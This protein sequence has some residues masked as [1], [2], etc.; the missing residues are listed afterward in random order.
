MKSLIARIRALGARETCQRPRQPDAKIAIRAKAIRARLAGAQ[1]CGTARQ[2]RDLAEK[3]QLEAGEK[4]A[5]AEQLVQSRRPWALVWCTTAWEP[6]NSWPGRRLVGWM[7]QPE[8]RLGTVQEVAQH[9]DKERLYALWLKG[10][11]SARRHGPVP[12]DGGD[13]TTDFIQ[14]TRLSDRHSLELFRHY[15]AA[16]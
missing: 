15:V 14:P 5:F 6:G 10:S 9:A 16:R 12:C 13:P 4:V 2:Y 7:V 1:G 3:D 11:R 8:V